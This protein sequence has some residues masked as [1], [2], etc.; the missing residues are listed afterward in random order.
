[1]HGG[2]VLDASVGPDVTHAL[3]DIGDERCVRVLDVGARCQAC[4]DL[5]DNRVQRAGGGVEFA[6]VQVIP[7]GGFEGDAAI[8]DAGALDGRLGGEGA[9]LELRAYCPALAL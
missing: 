8:G 3:D 9:G 4:F 5:G 2:E 7:E 6:L 1:V